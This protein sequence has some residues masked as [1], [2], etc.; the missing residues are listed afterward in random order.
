MRRV[1]QARPIPCPSVRLPVYYVR[2]AN[3][4][5]L[6]LSIKLDAPSLPSEL[7]LLLVGLHGDRIVLPG[8]LSL[9]R[10][11]DQ[12]QQERLSHPI[13]VEQ[14]ARRTLL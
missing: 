1:K 5:L 12:Q 10:S 11:P 2:T 8:L 3:D 14:G 13:L 4:A 7:L 6:S 9:I